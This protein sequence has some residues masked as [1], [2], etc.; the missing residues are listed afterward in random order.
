MC[1]VLAWFMD[2]SLKNE[3]I[4]ETKQVSDRAF[5]YDIPYSKSSTVYCV[6]RVGE[7]IT[8]WTAIQKTC[9]HTT[10]LFVD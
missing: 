1:V 2:V 9:P 7:T 8:N 3:S 6:Y 10:S 4:C 5:F